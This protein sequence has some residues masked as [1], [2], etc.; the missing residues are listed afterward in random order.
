MNIRSS[1]TLATSF[2]GL[3]VAA[4]SPGCGR[5]SP[6]HRAATNGVAGTA[7]AGTAAGGAG[8]SVGT[9]GASA[10]SAEAGASGGSGGDWRS[11]P[12]DWTAVAT[13]PGCSTRVARN[14]AAIWPGLTYRSCGTGCKEAKVLPV[15]GAPLAATLGTSA[16]VVDGTLKLSLSARTQ[17]DHTRY[18]LG[19]FA[20]GDGTPEVLVSEEGAC[21]AQM[22]G[23]GALSSFSIFGR[24]NGSQYRLGFFD[25]AQKTLS[26]LLLPLTVPFDA[27][28]YEQGWGGV[29]KFTTLLA[30]PDP[31]AAKL[32]TV[33]TSA[34]LMFY[35][36]SNGGLVAITESADNGGRILTWQPNHDAT[37][38]A[39]GAWTPVRLGLSADRIAWLGAKGD[40]VN[41][42]LYDSAAIYSCSRPAFGAA[43]QVQTGP[44]LPITTST[45]VLAT[46]GRFIVLNGCVE[47]GCDVYLDDWQNSVLYRVN[48]V[49][50]GHTQEAIAL[51][52]NE[53]FLADSSP[54]VIG[55]PDFDGFVRLDLEHV[56]D[57][58][59]KL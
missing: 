6:P 46:E 47:S 58:A 54:T 35:P 28:D 25:S 3:A 26:W 30:A 34:G 24:Q 15:D 14:P 36:T 57:F 4:A 45:G 12:D 2:I 33:Y 43:C 41:D 50:A 13:L 18:V 39:S 8:A 37:A 59:T 29:Q 20:Y 7:T 53:L 52:G 40:H 10:G 27:F 42:G 49:H 44:T 38:V 19:T 32:S 51:S 56:A 48:L 16:R 55:T 11:N 1:R 5:K 9:A 23:R 31:A 17:D 22:A 21:V